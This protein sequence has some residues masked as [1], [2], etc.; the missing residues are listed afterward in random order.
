MATPGS[1]SN[2]TKITYGYGLFIDEAAGYLRIYH[3][4]DVNGFS[5]HVVFYPEQ[6]MTVVILTNTRSTASRFIEQQ[7]T[8]LI[9]QPDS[10]KE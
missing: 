4:G 5:G 3:G 8:Q 1:L 2:L 9:A 6:D 10:I 7:I